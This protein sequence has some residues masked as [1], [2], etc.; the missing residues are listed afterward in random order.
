MKKVT[1]SLDDVIAS[2]ARAE[3]GRRG[4]SLS[5]FVRELIDRE[6]GREIER[7]KKTGL[8]AIEEFLNGPG[9]PDISKNWRGREDIYE[10]RMDEL[11]RRYE[12]SNPRNR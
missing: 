4:K 9:F 11:V 1:I 6:I 2:R 5:R 10:E 7:D 3:A 8:E 12:R